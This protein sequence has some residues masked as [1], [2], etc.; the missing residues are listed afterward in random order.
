MKNIPKIIPKTKKNR[1]FC[2]VFNQ[3]FWL[4][5]ILTSCGGKIYS[6]ELYAGEDNISTYESI[7][8]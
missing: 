7:L 8:S 1:R 5:S 3:D 2:L 6:A 4:L